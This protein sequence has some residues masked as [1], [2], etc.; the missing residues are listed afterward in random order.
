MQRSISAARPAPTRRRRMGGGSGYAAT[1][2]RLRHCTPVCASSVYIRAAAAR[3]SPRAFRNPACAANPCLGEPS[4][5]LLT[6]LGYPTVAQHVAR[7]DPRTA[8]VP[9]V[10]RGAHSAAAHPSRRPSLSAARNG[11]RRPTLPGLPA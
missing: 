7:R 5:Q 8:T 4:G 1:R 2:Y 9:A 10:L 11:G 6:P 3:S